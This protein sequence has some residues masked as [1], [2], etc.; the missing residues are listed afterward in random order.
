[1][2][3]STKKGPLSHINHYLQMVKFAHSL[4]ALPFAGIAFIEALPYSGLTIHNNPTLEFWRLLLGIILAMVSMRSAAMGFNRIVDRDF[5]SRN[6]RTAAREIPSGTIAVNHAWKFVILSLAVFIGTAFFIN[7]TAG[8][9]SPLAIVLTLGYS[10]TKRFTMFSHLALGMAIGSVPIAVWIAMLE[11]VDLL[12]VLWA[13]GMM[14]YIAGFDILY[15]CQDADFDR[16]I[17]LNSIP[18]RMGVVPALWYARISHTMA[19][20]FFIL[21]GVHGNLGWI[22]F[23]TVNIIAILFLIEHLLVRPNNLENVNIAFFHINASISS[24]IFAGLL[25]DRLL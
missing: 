9:F 17:G 21:A 8:L 1:M 2:N 7:F 11:R 6:P 23:A 19:L 5:D 4:F 14:F 25:L 16:D 24:V 10:Y 18:A 12:P 20:L 13:A 22:Y 15:S 3:G